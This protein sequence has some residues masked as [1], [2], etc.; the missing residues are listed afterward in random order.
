MLEPRGSGKFCSL[1]TYSSPWPQLWAYR[2]LLSL[3]ILKAFD[4]TLHSVIGFQGKGRVLRY[5]KNLQL[6]N[7]IP[8]DIWHE[9]LFLY[10][11]CILILVF[12][13]LSLKSYK[14]EVCAGLHA[15]ENSFRLSLYKQA[16]SQC[17]KQTLSDLHQ[18]RISILII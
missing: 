16:S 14:S 4:F 15:V 10:S 1:Q 13:L 17:I 18:H 5:K 11:Y 2:L 3:A 7:Y 8:L 12:P 6:T 9:L